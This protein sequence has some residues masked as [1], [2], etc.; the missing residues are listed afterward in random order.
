MRFAITLAFA[1]GGCVL[2][3]DI[4]HVKLRDPTNVAI[5]TRAGDAILA[6]G[7]TRGEIPAASPPFIY[8]PLGDSWVER[9]DASIEA[10][11]AHCRSIRRQTMLDGPELALEGEPAD[12]V[13]F[14]HHILHLRYLFHD[15][16]P[17]RRGGLYPVPRIRLELVTPVEN[18]VSIDYE[19]KVSDRNGGAPAERDPFMIGGIVFG[20]VYAAGGAA[21][22]VLGVAVHENGVIGAGAAMVA[23]GSGLI[24]FSW[25]MLGA[26]DRHAAIAVP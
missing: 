12:V 22:G 5:Q 11:C 21:I 13:R 25:H 2:R 24:A 9:H 7:A 3:D 26:K 6:P 18:V 10:W 14:D 23:V 20:S 17:G 16:I 8:D 4:V 1:L 19:S 15:G